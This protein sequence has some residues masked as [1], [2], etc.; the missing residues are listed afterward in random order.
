MEALQRIRLSVASKPMDIV[1]KA[2]QADTGR[3]I[4]FTI[5]DNIDFEGA[6]AR[7]YAVKP[8][9]L[10]VFNDVVIEGRDVVIELTPQTLAEIGVVN[11]QVSL[12]R[13]DD[14]ITSFEFYLSVEKNLSENGNIVS[15]NEFTALQN[16]LR[17]SRWIESSEVRY[18]SG[19]SGTV[20]PQGTWLI[21]PPNVAQGN[22]LWARLTLIHFD[23]TTT[24]MYGVSRNGIDGAI[25]N[26]AN[27]LTTTAAGI[28]LDARQGRILNENI[29][30]VNTSLFDRV[31]PVGSIYMSINGA[32]PSTLFGGT[33]EA[34]GQGRVPLGIG[35]NGTSNYLVPGATGGAETHALTAPEGPRHF[36]SLRIAGAS[37]P[38]GT[39]VN[40]QTGQ[41]GNNWGG[42][43]D[44]GVLATGEG[45]PHNNMQPWITCFM[46]LRVG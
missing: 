45:R 12:T 20:V 44:A 13:G 24:V 9:K 26:L 5:T 19:T 18:Q 6:K 31:Y 8:S 17:N 46:W 34:W 10:E 14:I 38:S 33:W 35:S 37:P 16:A 30:E 21:N 29:N 22:F 42:G 1:V 40:H 7:F 36:H 3:T 25:T 11:C 4:R 28:A 2:V 32:N 41:N 39:I 43:E 27:N 15:S 23:G